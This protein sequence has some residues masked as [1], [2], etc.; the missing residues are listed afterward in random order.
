M[1]GFLHGHPARDDEVGGGVLALVTRREEGHSAP[2]PRYALAN[3]RLI[4]TGHTGTRL[5]GGSI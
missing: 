3:L 5:A 1:H 2:R 4:A